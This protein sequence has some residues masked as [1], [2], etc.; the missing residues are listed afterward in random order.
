MGKEL[1]NGM[2]AGNAEMKHME[3]TIK[4]LIL[5]RYRSIPAERIM[6]RKLRTYLSLFDGFWEGQLWQT[7]LS[8]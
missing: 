6:A 5:K 4:Q 3:P 8:N 2:Q 1:G 7:F